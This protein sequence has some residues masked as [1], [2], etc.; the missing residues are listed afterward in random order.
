MEESR[1][2]GIWRHRTRLTNVK[3]IVDIG[4]LDVD[5][6]EAVG[7]TKKVFVKI[8]TA[9]VVVGEAIIAESDSTSDSQ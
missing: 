3:G 7:D 1:L 4:Q 9:E 8:D 2:S 6:G 5:V